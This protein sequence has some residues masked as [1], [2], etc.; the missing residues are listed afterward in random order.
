MR[1]ACAIVCGMRGIMRLLN[2]RAVRAVHVVPTACTSTMLRLACPSFRQLRTGCIAQWVPLKA[3]SPA[4]LQRDFQR[5]SSGASCL[6][7]GQCVRVA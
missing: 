5:P 1:A 4:D 3:W 2:A 6:P 7:W